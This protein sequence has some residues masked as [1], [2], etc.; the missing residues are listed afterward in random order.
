MSMSIPGTSCSLY[1][2]PFQGCKLLWDVIGWS[3]CRHQSLE[4]LMGLHYKGR[5]VGWSA[6]IRQGWKMSEIVVVIKNSI[7]C[8]FVKNIKLT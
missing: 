5:F 1:P 3:V 8:S 7:F 2:K 6:N 4:H